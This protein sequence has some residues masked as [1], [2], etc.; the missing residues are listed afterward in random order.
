MSY[1]QHLETI[2]RIQKEYRYYKS[3]ES[4]FEIDLWSFLPPQGGAYRQEMCAYISAQK[5]ALFQ[6]PEA[7]KAA[8]YFQKAGV[9]AGRD[10]IEQGLIRSFLSLS[11][12]L[13]QV[14]PDT[15]K[16]YK[17]LQAET[18]DCWKRAREKQDFFLF[19]PYLEKVFTLKKQIALEIRPDNDPFETL[20]QLTD[21]GVSLENL[22]QQFTVMA[23]G[24]KEL[25]EQISQ[26][27]VKPDSTLLRPQDPEAI[28]RFAQKLCLAVGYD[29]SKGAFNDRVVHAF[30]SFVGPKDSRISTYRSGSIALIF[31]YLHEAGHAIYAGSGNPQ[32]DAAGLWGGVEGGVHESMSRFHENM[33][34]R[35]L[36]FWKHF[37][38]MFQEEFPDYKDISLDQFYCALH[39]VKP[40][41]RRISSDEVTYNLHILIR[42]ELERE[43][44]SGRL[45][46]E[47][48]RDAWNQKYRSY[49]GITPANDTEGIL[50]DMHW[51]GDYIGYFQSYALGNLYDGQILK[52]MKQDLPHFGQ[53]LEQGN[54]VPIQDWLRDRIGQY[55][56]A[57]VGPLLMEQAVSSPLDAR[58]F[59]QYLKDKYGKIYQLD[60]S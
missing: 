44:F 38:P 2:Q 34:G 15:M 31:T 13:G 47:D 60:K 3:I 16:A 24:L 28:A 26:S 30:S 53:L 37:Y 55:G 41:A 51:A 50:Q 23:Q 52:A 33:I 12:G 5:A 17:M 56:Q 18:M 48:M 21:E 39:Q 19:A 14:S 20:V 9:Q 32:V 35:S 58:P 25:R 36:G 1:A 57:I 40:R 29:P 43:W 49:L 11:F 54:F 7:R 4:L 27:P 46:T 22:D 59:L 6:Q 45:K 10:W 42:Y 8:D